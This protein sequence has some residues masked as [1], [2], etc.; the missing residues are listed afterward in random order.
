MW[1]R[2]SIRIRKRTSIQSVPMKTIQ[3]IVLLSAFTLSLC[4][5]FGPASISAADNNL[6]QNGEFAQKTGPWILQ[7]LNGAK[8]TMKIENSEG[9]SNALHISVVE[10]SP[11]RYHIQLVQKNIN[12]LPNKTYRLRFRARSEPASQLVIV[13]LPG[14]RPTEKLWQQDHIPLDQEWKE[15]SYEFTLAS[16]EEATSFALSGL[17]KQTGDYFFSD[18]SLTEV[19]P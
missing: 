4:I 17:A 8:A 9:Q 12:L 15:Y 7:C 6:F 3:R 2:H 10:T 18:L 19:T 16:E 1:V 14:K 5:L 11:M 13:L